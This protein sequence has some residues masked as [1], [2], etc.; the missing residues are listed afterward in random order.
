MIIPTSLY[1]SAYNMLS[2]NIISIYTYLHCNI[3]YSIKHYKSQFNVYFNSPVKYTIAG[4]YMKIKFST[5]TYFN[6]PV[7]SKP[8]FTKY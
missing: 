6:K 7:E 8:Q 3:K 1:R 4:K 5:V 2:V